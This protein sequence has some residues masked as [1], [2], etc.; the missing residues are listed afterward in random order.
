M[1]FSV[2]LFHFEWTYA[3]LNPRK[4]YKTRDSVFPQRLTTTWHGQS[5]MDSPWHGQK[6]FIRKTSNKLKISW[7]FKNIRKIFNIF[8]HSK[9]C[10]IILISQKNYIWTMKKLQKSSEFSLC[11]TL[12]MHW[13]YEQFPMYGPYDMD[14]IKIESSIII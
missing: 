1:H 5:D 9:K 12:S 6:S 13:S 11:M 10:F 14:Y 8:R 4:N 3:H 7:I 2:G